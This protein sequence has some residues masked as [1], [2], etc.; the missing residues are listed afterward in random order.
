MVIL[1][2]GVP[3][4]GNYWLY[5][6]VRESLAQA[7]VPHRSFV[8][9][10]PIH[11]EAQSWELSFQGQAD[12][13]FLVIEP[14][15]C[16]FRISALYREPL[17]DVAAYVGQCRQVWTHSGFCERSR[18]VLPLFDRVVYLIRDPRDVALSYARFAFTPHKLKNH[19][20]HHEKDPESFL[21]HRFDGMVRDW[22]QHVGGYLRH[23]EA[24][25]I[26]VVFY[27]RLLHHFDE[28]LEALLTYL[29]LELDA[30]QI[31]EVTER[32]TFAHMKRHSPDHLR[33]GRSGQWVDA[34]T[35]EQQAHAERV[36]GPMLELLGY[37]VEAPATAERGPAL[38]G[39]VDPEALERAI[40]AS[41]RS[42]M[43]EVQRV[44][45]FLLSDRS[46]RAK[47]D[48]MRSWVRERWGA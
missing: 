2:A 23:R 24:L 46:W 11:A 18:R 1:Q 6:I 22:V 5:R 42:A 35:P 48:R 7:G 12:M 29:G 16:S 21:A 4:S 44:A 36:A 30:A 47:T 38:P 28:E 26:H 37:P 31:R 33:K 14:E 3:K 13:D 17:A 8:Q 45:G 20:P 25:G 10:H 27:E 43:E 9:R 40:A 19:P 32:V 34:L 39:A 41:E 15:G